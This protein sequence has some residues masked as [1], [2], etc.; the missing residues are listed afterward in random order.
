MTASMTIQDLQASILSFCATGQEKDTVRTLCEAMPGLD[1]QALIEAIASLDLPDM[2][3]LILLRDTQ[4]GFGCAPG[5]CGAAFAHA[6]PGSGRKADFIGSQLTVE[7]AHA[8]V[9]FFQ[10]TLKGVRVYL[11]RDDRWR[12]SLHF[13]V[14]GL[15]SRPF[16]NLYTPWP[17]NLRD[18]PD[19]QHLRLDHTHPVRTDPRWE[20]PI[21]MPGMCLWDCPDLRSV[22][23]RGRTMLLSIRGCPRLATLPQDSAFFMDELMIEPHGGLA[24]QEGDPAPHGLS[25]L[26]KVSFHPGPDGIIRT[27]LRNADGVLE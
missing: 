25:S 22:D 11:R 13:R 8:W 12:T 9:A 19:L 17:V 15:S 6:L 20:R 27:A 18:C 7:A 14:A 1:C 2:T 16:L 4:D 10:K 24:F 5:T 3:R 26:G 21:P 23:A